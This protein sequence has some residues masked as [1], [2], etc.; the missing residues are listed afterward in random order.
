VNHFADHL[1]FLG[2]D[3]LGGYPAFLAELPNFVQ[4]FY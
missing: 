1:A 3:H 2:V 4:L